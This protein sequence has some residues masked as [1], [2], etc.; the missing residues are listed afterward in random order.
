MSTENKSK[1]LDIQKDICEVTPPPEEPVKICPTCVPD[2][3]A[4]VPNWWETEQPYLDKRQCLYSVTVATNDDGQIY[5]VARMTSEGLGIKEL[6]ETYKRFGLLQ[7]MRFYNK[8]ISNETLFAFP[9]DPDK[10]ERLNQRA[11]RDIQN[12][13]QVLEEQLPNGS[14]SVYGIPG[15]ILESFDIKEGD[16]FN[17]LGAEL[18]IQANDY[19]V[20]SFQTATGGEPILVRV[21]IPAFVFDRI[22]E[23]KPVEEADIQNEVILDGLNL[24]AQIQRLKIAMGVFGKYQAYW[25]QTE[26][27]RLVF[28]KTLTPDQDLTVEEAFMSS[29]GVSDFYCRTYPNKLDSFVEKLETLIESQTKYKFRIIRTPRSV[30]FVKI[31]FNNSNP[32]RPYRIKKIE[33]KGGG[34]DYEKV[35]LGS[36]KKLSADGSDKFIY[37]FNDQTVLGYVANINDIDTDIQAKETPPW[38]DFCLQYT[39]PPLVIEYG[40]ANQLTA[41]FGQPETI[42]GCV[43][44]NLGGEDAIRDFF[45]E[46]VMTFFDSIA[47]KFNQNSCKALAGN[48]VT[49]EEQI[50]QGAKKTLTEQRQDQKAEVTAA[51]D[52]EI[53]AIQAEIARLNESIQY[54]EQQIK[55]T[56]KLRRDEESNISDLEIETRIKAYEKE[57]KAAES[58]IKDNKEKLKPLE[59]A[60]RKALREDRRSTGKAFRDA[61]KKEKKARENAQSQVNFGRK[62]KRSFKK[63]LKEDGA[64]RKTRR[65]ALRSVENSLQDLEDIAAGGTSRENRLDRRQQRGQSRGENPYTA[66]ARNIVSEQFPFEDS[67]IQ[68]FLTEEEFEQN[69]L[70]GIDIFGG[71]S[72]LSSRG[73]GES[74]KKRLRNIISRLGICGINRLAQRVIQCLLGGVD[75]STGLRSIIRST[76][77]NMNPN[78]MEKLLIGLDPRVQDDIRKQVES[79]FGDM[80]APWEVGY[81]P[82]SRTGFV[83]ETRERAYEDAIDS[84]QTKIDEKKQLI[85]KIR[86]TQNKVKPLTDGVNQEIFSFLE[87]D[88]QDPGEQRIYDT[89]KSIIPETGPVV[90]AALGDLLEQ[91]GNVEL[92]QLEEELGQTQTDASNTKYGSWR[93]LSTEEQ[94]ELIAR[95]RQVAD[96]FANGETNRERINQGSVGKALG[97]VQELVFEAYIDAIMD[98]VEIQELFSILDKVP[99]ARLVARLIASFDCPNVHFIHPPIKSF[100][101]SLTFDECLDRGSLKLPMIPRLPKIKTIKEYLFELLKRAF[102][103]AK[104]QL[105]VSVKAA[106]ML[107]LL[108]TLENALCKALETVG[109]F[110][111]EAVKGPEADFGSVINDVICGGNSDDEEIDDI[112]SSL[113]TSIGITPQRLNALA[114]AQITPA[115]I[116][117]QHKEVMNAISN[118]VSGKE[119]KKLLV[120][121]PGEMENE[122]LRRISRSVADRFPA[123]GIFFD[124]PAKVESVFGALGNFITPEQRQAIRDN[125][126]DPLI[127]PGDNKSICLTQE[128]LEAFEDEQRN[129]FRN[130]GLDDETI[131]EILAK[132]RENNK[133]RLDDVLDIL[134]KGPAN[135]ISEALDKALLPEECGNPNGIANLETPEMAKE[136]DILVEG[137]F[138]SLQKSYGNDMIGKRDSFLD[139]VLADTTDLQLKRHERRTKSDTFYIDYVN[140]TEDWDAKKKKFEKTKTGEFYFQL[141]SQ[142][143]AKGV[144]PDTVAIFLKEQLEE[145]TFDVNYSLI[146]KALPSRETTSIEFGFLGIDRDVITRKPYLKTPDMKITFD[147]NDDVQ[148]ELGIDLMY[149]KYQNQEV[150]IERDFG[151]KIDISVTQVTTNVPEEE[152]DDTAELAQRLFNYRKYAIFAPQ[153]IDESASVVLA[154]YDVDHETLNQK[155]VPYQSYILTNL[156]NSQ[157]QAASG[158]SINVKEFTNSFY[159]NFTKKSFDVLSKGLLNELDGTPSNGF[160]FGYEADPLTPD[161]LLYVNPESDPNDEDTWEY[162]Y[163]KEDNVLGRSATKHPRVFFLDPNVYG[164]SYTN[165]A[166][167]VEPAT[168]TGWMGL[169]QM[170]VPEIDGCKPKRTDFIDIKQIAT[171]VREIQ[172]SIPQDPRLSEDPECVKRI[173]F[174]K[175]SDP[176]TLA[177]LDGIVTATI[178]TYASEAMLKSMPMFSFLMYKDSNYDNGFAQMI[179][180]EMQDGLIDETALFGGRIEGYNYWLL[181]LEQAVQ[182]AVRKIDNG[183]IEST[184]EIEEARKAI[185]DIQVSYR[186]PQRDDIADLANFAELSHTDALASNDTA[187]IGLFTLAFPAIVSTGGVMA[188]PIKLEGIITLNELRFASKIGAIEL[189]KRS[190]KVLLNALVDKELSFLAEKLEGDTRFRPYVSDISKYYLSLPDFMYGSTLKAGLMDVENPIVGGESNIE[191]GDVNEVLSDSANSSLISSLGLN[192][193]QTAKL[194]EAGGLMIEK[195]IRTIDKPQQGPQL[196]NQA[197]EDQ[198]EP[199]YLQ[200]IRQRPSSLKGVCNI[201]EFRQWCLGV[202]DQIPSELNISDLFGDAVAPPEGSTDYEGSIGIKYGVRISLL[203]NN[204]LNNS[205]S[206]GNFDADFVT[207]EKSYRFADTVAIPIVTYERDLND[208]KFADL[209]FTDS[210]L[211]EDLKCYIDKMVTEPEYRFVMDYALGLNRIPTILSIYMAQNFVS[212]VGKSE[213]ERD[214]DAKLLGFDTT[215]EEWKT[216]ILS[217]TKKECRQLFAAFYRSNDFNPEDDNDGTLRDFISRILP[218]VFGVNRGLIHWLRR[219]RLRDRPF[220]KNGQFCKNGFQRLFS[221]D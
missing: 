77:N 183:E 8:E 159:K 160:S 36:I 198:Q 32:D 192:E 178:R 125:L 191:Y 50:A 34:C 83:G 138:R 156:I 88:T 60:R 79:I 122:V 211:G 213:S 140:S 195:Y 66:A 201:T 87:L 151:Y 78:Y 142:E 219:K 110:A 131:N 170:L 134:A 103:E 85:D 39:F 41:E 62:E 13:I 35:P 40:K 182:A 52:P 210:D 90:S 106:L 212:S 173:P 171:K 148:T 176:S 143:E 74:K 76:L 137:V 121:N 169:S 163:E 129:T 73:E 75:L 150:T 5:D 109:Q 89:I 190:C 48:Y 100:L 27:G 147:N 214:E 152:V 205:L 127:D 108:I 187:V 161:D 49:R 200:V 98:N 81:Q 215:S 2:P 67:L 4:I 208:V 51:Y 84:I 59:Q 115:S 164:G 20:S 155:K 162:T 202:K 114:E 111:A 206:T 11:N 29:Q 54:Y 58:L 184:P 101:S 22:P 194:S 31:S 47:Y 70:S 38:I 42:L 14:F 177:F 33:V 96:Q 86:E 68:L 209:D 107:K 116:K 97:S 216:E 133:Q 153:A 93:N 53:Q 175:I 217:D 149:T 166:L 37:P 102:Q 186:Y 132:N 16:N 21:T 105:I 203:P 94:E 112:A 168:Y 181:F 157:L 57:I 180:Q 221:P 45:L 55:D 28:Q 144:F 126:A 167:Y 18:Y 92:K 44:D 172:T 204:I 119:L 154:Q 135:L 158:G 64:S 174:D 139:N 6:I 19:Y 123:F 124:T 46:T 189:V 188:D 130:A 69:G 3:S 63:G 17:P 72:D 197:R 104:E 91:V 113:L 120:A 24:K 15:P 146:P 118:V 25:W 12:S 71:L 95:E 7:L 136:N 9:D 56:K 30:E 117:D 141:F 43:I 207:R 185:N 218:G 23:A 165:P 179:V 128:Q 220:D 199:Q 80:P 193:E 10:L 99:G 145:Q 65:Q 196:E 82:G 26:K 61:K 1:F